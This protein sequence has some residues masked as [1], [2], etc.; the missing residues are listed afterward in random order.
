AAGGASLTAPPCPITRA[1]GSAGIATS[2]V[3]SISLREN[4][5]AVF[6]TF[7][8]A[9]VSPSRGRQVRLRVHLNPGRLLRDR[10]H[11][12]PHDAAHPDLRGD[13]EDPLRDDPVEHDR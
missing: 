7:P 1:R 12:H 10:S 8:F 2:A 3:V 11:L 4:P 5:S 6:S 9:M 13:V